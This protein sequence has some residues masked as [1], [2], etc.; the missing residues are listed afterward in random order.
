MSGV[1]GLS[2]SNDRRH[3]QVVS[4]LRLSLVSS[5]PNA[6]KG[7]G[8]VSDDDVLYGYRLRFFALR[9]TVDTSG[10]PADLRL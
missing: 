5:S 1:S 9:P 3:P 2:F 6:E 7:G 4:G 10:P 8:A